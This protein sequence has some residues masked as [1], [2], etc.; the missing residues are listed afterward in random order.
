MVDVETLDAVLERE[1]VDNAQLL[2]I[3]AEGFDLEVLRG[4]SA[5]L[6]EQRFD[7]IQIEAGF[8]APGPAMTS[9]A[10]IQSLLAGHRYFLHLITNQCHARLNKLEGGES[11][12]EANP[13]VLVYCDAIFVA[14]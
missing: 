6:A 12:T 8:C 2:K 3:D 14:G 7:I 10:E 5:A 4:A 13:E 11:G 1:D 9:L